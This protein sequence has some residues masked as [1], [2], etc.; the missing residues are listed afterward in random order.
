M[1]EKKNDTYGLEHGVLATNVASGNDT[2]TSDE[3]SSDVGNN[4]TVQVGHDHNVE[5]LGLGDKLHGGV[6]DNHVVELD[7]RAGILLGDLTAGVEEETIGQLHDV[8]LVD[9]GDLLAAVAESKVKGEARNALRLGAG[10][11]LE[12]LDNTGVGLV[13]EARVLTLGVLT[14]DGK[15]NSL[16]AG[17]V[18]R[19]VFA[20]DQGGVHVQILA[21]GDVEG[22]VA[23]GGGGS[24]EDSLKTDLV[25]SEGLDRLLEG[26]VISSG[27]SRDVKLLPVNGDVGGLEDGLDGRGSLLTNTVSGNQGDGVTTTK[28]GGRNLYQEKQ[29]LY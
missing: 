19:D 9:A 14:D 15:V 29:R 18:A 26:G 13:L 2:G 28:L 20:E 22:R 1:R 21:N 7:A 25:A 17:G 24:V 16:V 6:V 27:V 23:G 11:D 10:D 5:L 8:G 4:V 3:T 12:G